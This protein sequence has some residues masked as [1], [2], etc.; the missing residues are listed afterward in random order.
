MNNIQEISIF[1]KD[2]KASKAVIKFSIETQTESER[3]SS[4][5]YSKK[6]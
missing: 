6:K 4:I 1:T 5:K 2:Q 3:F